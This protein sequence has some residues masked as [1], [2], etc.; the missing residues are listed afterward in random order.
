MAR[1]FVPLVLVAVLL[2]A[3]APLVVANA[4]FEQTMGLVQKI[5]STTCRP[6]C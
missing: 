4:P 2:F 3:A 5:F 6:R 1:L